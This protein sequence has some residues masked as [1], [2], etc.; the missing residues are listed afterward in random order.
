MKL[1]IGRTFWTV[2][3]QAVRM[4]SP[5]TAQMTHALFMSAPFVREAF[6][7]IEPIIGEGIG[8]AKLARLFAAA[9]TASV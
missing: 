8:P 2:M 6:P 9:R 5:A 7:V 4:A 1:A 3:A